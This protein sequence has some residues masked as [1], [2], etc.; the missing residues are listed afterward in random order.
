[1]SYVSIGSISGLAF[2]YSSTPRSIETPVDRRSGAVEPSAWSYLT[3]N[4]RE[5]ITAIFGPE[6]LASGYD[7]QGK[8]VEIPK[9][10]VVLIDHRKSG[11]LTSGVEV[12]STY[13][14]GMWDRYESQPAG[15]PD[16]NPLSA[17]N[18]ADGLDFLG[19]RSQGGAVD[20]RA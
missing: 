15:S 6:A 7:D 1:V 11:Q 2:A 13:L 19:R 9:F 3:A 16:A 12:T 14:Q 8:P 10:A 4:D 17:Q 5:L 18:L 20:L